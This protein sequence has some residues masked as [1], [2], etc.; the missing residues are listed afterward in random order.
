MCQWNL[1]KVSEIMIAKFILI[2]SDKKNNKKQQ[3][4]AFFK[5]H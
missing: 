2:K 4:F 1:F 3:K 5:E